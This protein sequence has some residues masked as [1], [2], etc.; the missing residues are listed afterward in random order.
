MFAF[1]WRLKQ[2]K[3][4]VPGMF[5]NL[6]KRFPNVIQTLSNCPELGK[7]KFTPNNLFCFT[8]PPNSVLLRKL[9]LLWL[10]GKDNIWSVLIF[11]KTLPW[12]KYISNK[13]AGKDNGGEQLGFAEK[14]KEEPSALTFIRQILYFILVPFLMKFQHPLKL[15]FLTSE[16][17]DL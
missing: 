15:K 13:L 12:A 4:T 1:P 16:N 9:H 3:L 14:I 5:A 6:C 17:Q 11:P 7:L 8:K 10:G 2:N